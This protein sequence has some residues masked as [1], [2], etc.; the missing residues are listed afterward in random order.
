MKNTGSSVDILKVDGNRLN[1]KFRT[2]QTRFITSQRETWKISKSE[3]DMASPMDSEQY[4]VAAKAAIDESEFFFVALCVL[5]L[6][7]SFV[8]FFFWSAS[9]VRIHDRVALL[10]LACRGL[11]KLA[12]FRAG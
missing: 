7:L 11:Q 6:F 8:F 12:K 9:R 1:L 5:L 3:A 4:R 2:H 10:Q